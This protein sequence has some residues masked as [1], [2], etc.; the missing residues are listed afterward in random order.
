MP[1]PTSHRLL[2]QYR[3]VDHI[4]D[5]LASLGVSHLFGVGGANIE[6]LYD[7]VQRHGSITGVLAKHEFSAATMADGFARTT[8][9]LGVVAATSGG[10]ALNLLAGLGEAF[11]SRVPVL[12]LAGQPPTSLTGQGVFQDSSGLTG[13]LDGAH[14]F[15]A[16]SR[17]CA[18]VKD[19]DEL[20]ALLSEA[21]SAALS[22]P[23]GPA[24]LLLP[25]D[26]QQAPMTSPVAASSACD[27]VTAVP[28]VTDV[29][30]Q[31]ERARASGP[32]VIIA[33]DGV[34][35]ANAR[36]GLARLAERLD[37]KVAVA[38]DARDVFDNHHA[39]FLGV[40]GIMGHPAVAEHL[41]TASACLLVGTRL[42]MVA[43]TGLEQI[44]TEIPVICLDNEQP[45]VDGTLVPGALASTLAALGDRLAPAA[46]TRPS[47]HRAPEPLRVPPKRGSG[48]G[49]AE[50]VTAINA[51]VPDNAS[52]FVDAGNACAAVIHNILAPK[53]GRFVVAL[54]MGGMGYTFGA[55]IGATFGGAAR[56]YVLA[57]DGAFYMHGLEIHTAVEYDLP[58]TFV[59]MNNNAHAMCV[60]REQL[61]YGGEYSYNRFRKSDLAA[62][63]AAMF[64]SLN[65]YAPRTV[66]DLATALF[67]SNATSGPAFVAVDCD[68][69]EIPPFVPFLAEENHCV[70][71]G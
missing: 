60:T 52:V 2:D 51:A 17:Y 48:L 27:G 29:A 40:A 26:I 44:L 4:V 62:G 11:M 16:V 55:G 42:P 46:T 21:I 56:T 24:V 1:S 38:P 25:K 41:R 50:V 37:A 45:F 57:G 14:V 66:D 32:V 18:L 10:G 13:S 15:S 64:P 43:R 3:A 9:Q 58:V 23:H 61:Y 71:A 34:A 31:I 47:V 54:G 33:G 35:R 8:N 69:D 12:A 7:A 65:A 70:H 28:D 20:P 22:A 67:E 63:V 30:D 19:V 53:H 68:P 36:P 49:Y 39:R 6:D 5:R 59:I